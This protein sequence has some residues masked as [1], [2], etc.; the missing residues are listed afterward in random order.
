[1]SE[2]KQVLRT[3]KIIVDAFLKLRQTHSF[4]D[5]SVTDI[6][7]QAMIARATF[8]KYY[9]DKY[10]LIKTIV[11]DYK[12]RVFDKVLSSFTYTTP[13]EL[14]LKIAEI[15]LDFM[16]ERQ[17]FWAVYL[18]TGISDRVC[19]MILQMVNDYIEDLLEALE[20]KVEYLVPVSMLSKFFTGGFAY[21]GIHY[22]EE[23]KKYTKQ[24]IL[25]YLEKM[26]DV[27]AFAKAK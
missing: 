21:L 19:M 12:E 7:E 17:E 6:C 27:S 3:R 11:Q 15:C 13:K 18:K 2:S 4:D 26:L 20:D 16:N 5:I 9:E 23:V 1:M 22:M 10:H 14:Y 8:Y 25:G 24:E